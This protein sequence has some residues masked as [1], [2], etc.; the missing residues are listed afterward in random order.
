MYVYIY[1]YIYNILYI[2]LFNYVYHCLIL[3]SLHNFHWSPY[4][5][6]FSTFASYDLDGLNALWDDH[7]HPMVP[8]TWKSPEIHWNP[9]IKTMVSCGC[10]IL[11][12]WWGMGFLSFCSPG[13]E[14]RKKTWRNPLLS[15]VWVLSNWKDCPRFAFPHFLADQ[16]ISEKHVVKYPSLGRCTPR[17]K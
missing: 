3:C 7:P 17:T 1:V 12:G 15:Q 8:K 5:S 16:S 10:L 9:P 14:G 6:E 13:E 2:Y 11:G 4:S